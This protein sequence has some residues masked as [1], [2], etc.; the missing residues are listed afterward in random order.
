MYDKI[1]VAAGDIWRELHNQGEIPITKLNR[2]TGLPVGLFYMA[3][4][5]LSRE[6][7]LCYRRERRKLYVALK[8]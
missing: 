5:W 8:E 3:L 1:G 6:D 7:K 2:K 4:G